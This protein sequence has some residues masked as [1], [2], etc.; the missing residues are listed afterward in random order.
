ME[1]LRVKWRRCPEGYKIC[2][3]PPGV[4]KSSGKIVPVGEVRAY[5]LDGIPR[6]D[7]ALQ[8]ANATNT[9]RVL[10]FVADWGLPHAHA[11]ALDKFRR[12]EGAFRHLLLANELRSLGCT[13]LALDRAIERG[14]AL[15]TT[16]VTSEGGVIIYDAASLLGYAWLALLHRIERDAQ[17]ASC[18]VCSDWYLLRRGTQVLCGS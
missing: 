13:T 18:P 7:V 12:I 8:L 2:E 15:A 3:A 14:A 4:A 11:H 17:F 9:E 5:T 16:T 10:Q 6:L 1:K